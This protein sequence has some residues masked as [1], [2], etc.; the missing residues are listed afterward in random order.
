EQLLKD[1]GAVLD[2]DGDP[3]KGALVFRQNCA[4]CHRLDGEGANVGPDLGA[5]GSKSPQTLLVAIFDP[6]RTVKARYVND[7]ALTES[8]REISVV[9]VAEPPGRVTLRSVGGNEETI[10]RSDLQQLSS[11]G[12]PLL[13]EGFENALS[14][15]E[16]ADLLAFLTHAR[17][18]GDRR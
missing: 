2:L 18:A 9:M 15:Q 14:R 13:P 4:T 3:S 12:L 6:N 16:L 10:L 1:Y 11:S 17:K 5:L 8:D 7:T